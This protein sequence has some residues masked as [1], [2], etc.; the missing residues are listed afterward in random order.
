MTDIYL[1][2]ITGNS[3]GERVE[4]EEE[5][6]SESEAILHHDD[7]QVESCLD[8]INFRKTP[9]LP[10]FGEYTKILLHFLPEKSS[11]I[12]FEATIVLLFKILTVLS[13]RRFD[14]ADNRNIDVR[15]AFSQKA[16]EQCYNR[17]ENCKLS[18]TGTITAAGIAASILHPNKMIMWWIL[19]FLKIN[20]YD[21]DTIGM[22]KTF[23]NNHV[24]I[25]PALML[26]DTAKTYKYGRSW[27]RVVKSKKPLPK[28]HAE[29][30]GRMK[31][32]RQLKQYQGKLK[33]PRVIVSIMTCCN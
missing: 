29:D 28:P 21:A 13:R 24:E 20:S 16:V 30:S 9:G 17:Q 15:K 31:R 8:V 2:Y 33:S 6:S 11:T 25:Y 4:T 18:I 12:D 1:Y 27:Y 26:N 19:G 3:D 23:I 22:I 14:T 7:Q 10:L 32:V 5:K